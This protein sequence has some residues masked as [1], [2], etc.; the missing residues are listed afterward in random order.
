[1]LYVLQ[2]TQEP[3]TRKRGHDTVPKPTGAFQSE[4]SVAA[5]HESLKQVK[6]MIYVRS[7]IR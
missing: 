5:I 7:T 4:E 6:Q 2:S 1:M 3:S